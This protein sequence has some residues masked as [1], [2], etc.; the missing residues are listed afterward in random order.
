MKQVFLIWIFLFLSLP[1]IHGQYQVQTGIGK[2]L[3]HR[4]QITFETNRPF[5]FIDLHYS[6]QPI[7]TSSWHKY[8]NLASISH[9]ISY[10]NFGNNDV[11]GYGLS[12]IPSIQFYLLQQ[13]NWNLQFSLGSGIA[14]INIVYDAYDNPLNNVISSHWNNHTRFQ[15]ST[16]FVAN[17]KL[18]LSIG[19]YLYHYSNA[20]AK[21]PNLG[22][23][24]YGINLN[25]GFISKPKGQRYF[26]LKDPFRE[27]E[28]H[29][30]F[31]LTSYST[32]K[33]TSLIPN[34]PKHR[35]FGLSLH[36]AYH[37]HKYVR[38]I[39]GAAYEY[40]GEAYLFSRETF[41]TKSHDDAVKFASLALLSGGFEC[42]F[43]PIGLRFT[44]GV[45]LKNFENN[46]FNR[47]SA[48]YYFSLPNSHSKF[49]IGVNLKSHA[50]VADYGAL[51]LSYQF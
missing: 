20:L 27:S 29:F 46:Y 1:M 17:D 44:P 9:A 39:A 13:R 21:S 25:V 3:K 7:D 48:L 28:K 40:N 10:A 30:K 11:L 37:V 14:W 19:I 15:I 49:A 50:L 47:L 35:I 6:F 43:G 4:E 45:Y 41:Q 23:N 34:G 24:P 38:L 31:L 18:K 5:Q 32:Q 22:I 51:T 16:A 12:Y 26:V 42:L 33:E 2:I 36:T 8:W